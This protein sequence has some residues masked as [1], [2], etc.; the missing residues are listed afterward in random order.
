VELLSSYTTSV[1]RVANII[2]AHHRS[3]Y[4]RS[5]VGEPSAILV[6]IVSIMLFR[7]KYSLVITKIDVEASLEI[8]Q[9]RS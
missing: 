7:S 6:E 2:K 1:S 9:K 8:D 3:E 4:K 5:G